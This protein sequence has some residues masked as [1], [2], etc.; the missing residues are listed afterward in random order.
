MTH[1][2]GPMA[3][4][5]L[6]LSLGVSFIFGMPC[7]LAVDEQSVLAALTLNFARFTTWPEASSERLNVCVIGDNVIQEAFM[8][9][10]GVDV[11]GR[12]VSV[13]NMSRLTNLASCQVLFIHDLK[14]NV[15]AQVFQELRDSPVLTVG[16]GLDILDN[17][18][19]IGLDNEGGKVVI[20]I[21]LNQ[22]NRSGLKIS[23]R[24]LQL[25]VIRE[26]GK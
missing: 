8:P 5:A 21:D 20:H 11:N 16:N 6:Y 23:S 26:N 10:Q 9:L 14:R 1:Q 4:I 3:R 17:G 13:N 12:K 15:M 24:L 2:R 25:A 22:V 19:M 18:G 7:A